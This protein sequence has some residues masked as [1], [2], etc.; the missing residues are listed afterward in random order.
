MHEALTMSRT[1]ANLPSRL[2]RVAR[3]A[4][5]ALL[6]AP[7]TL[8]AGCGDH[9][10]DVVVYC[11]LDRNFS[12]PIVR[13]FEQETG[14]EV[15]LETD[16]EASK[17]VGLVRRIEEEA[18]TRVRGDVFWNN[19]IL[20]TL[21]LKKQ[22]L[23]SPYR[24]P[25]AAGI[26]AAFVDPDGAWHGFA[27]RA[28]VFIVN[29]D[30][31]PDPAQWPRSLRDLADPRF[32]GQVAMAKPLTG[33]TLTHVAALFAAWGEVET[34]AFLDALDANE[35]AWL[36]GNAHVMRQVRDGNYAFG[37]TDTDDLNV[38][39]VDGYPV[40]CVYPD[41]GGEGTLV[42]PNT[43]AM[44]H[45]GPHPDA[46]KRFIDFVL[47][48]EVEKELAHSTSAQIPL[49]PGVERPEHVKSPG[50]FTALGV[51][52]ARVVEAYDAHHDEL[53]ERFLQR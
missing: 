35:V 6:L 30:E 18:A 46:A 31:L 23:L 52:F 20:H 10:P 12:E 41:D 34:R 16:V 39:L 48:A 22:G 47:S 11:A 28:R 1:F 43:I 14:L 9:G 21:R 38:A 4:A 42:I 27:A 19:E 32:K 53:R 25:S 33:T 5:L 44:L 37:L 8:V 49:R 26:P 40:A 13:R 15:K 24:S 3:A 51:D 45:G 29:T 50:D 7:L 36:A 17:T 2:A